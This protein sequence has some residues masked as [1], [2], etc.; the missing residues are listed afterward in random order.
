MKP[1]NDDGQE[2]SLRLRLGPLRYLFIPHDAWGRKTISHLARN[3]DARSFTG[4]PD[5]VFHLLDCLSVR[6]RAMAVGAGHLPSQYAA[7]ISGKIPG[8]G[9]KH[10]EDG[11]GGIVC[12]HHRSRHVLWEHW[13]PEVE[14]APLFW[15]PWPIMAQDM[16]RCG[17][18]L[19]HGGLAVLNG[20]AYVFT[21]PPG[22]GKTTALSRMP[23]PWRVLTDDAAL[24]WRV[25]G[26][27]FMASP[28][29]AWGALRRN[30]QTLAGIGKWKV[31]EA[32]EIAGVFLLKK[33]PKEKLVPLQPIEAASPLCRAFSE[34]PGVFESR[35][36]FRRR[37]FHFACA[38][39]MQ[40]PT[41]RLELSRRG[42][43]WRLLE[44]MCNG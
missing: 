12:W 16:M 11:A 6:D 18:G 32:A 13:I 8:R 10:V 31:S 35:G 20:R 30:E 37:L 23:E 15:L 29:P 4:V 34:H 40:V 22:G 21:A 14:P 2:S 38:M 41:W 7:V 36:P 28:L 43:F 25:A 24:V 9:W 44:G 26:G 27:R 17:G 3:V 19:L 1:R 33:R 42:D 39:V 5:R